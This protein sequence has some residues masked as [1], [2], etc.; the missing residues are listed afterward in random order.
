MAKP[1]SFSSD[2]EI[3]QIDAKLLHP[4]QMPFNKASE[5][6]LAE[7]NSELKG[8]THIITVSYST[9]YQPEVAINRKEN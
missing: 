2:F 7:L 5:W 8:L 4:E 6:V 3:R 9:E 1:N